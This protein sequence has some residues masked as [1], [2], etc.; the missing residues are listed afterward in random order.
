MDLNGDTAFFW[1]E[2]FMKA[3]YYAVRAVVK[4]FKTLLTSQ[5][6]I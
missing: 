3:L 2:S 6:F 5:F 1:H 4:Y